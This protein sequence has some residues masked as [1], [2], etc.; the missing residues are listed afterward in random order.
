MTSSCEI[1]VSLVKFLLSKDLGV[2]CTEVPFASFFSE[3]SSKSTGKK[4]A[5]KDLCAVLWTV[6]FEENYENV[7]NLIFF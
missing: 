6:A 7:Q 5:K 4:L 2:Q 1:G 3:N